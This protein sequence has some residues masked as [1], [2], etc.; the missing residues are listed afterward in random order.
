MSFIEPPDLYPSG[1]GRPAFTLLDVRAPVEVAAGGL[2]FAVTQPI[3]T[4]DERRRVGIRYR[5]AGQA[6]AV[7]LG[8][9]LTETTMPERVAAWREVVAAGPTAV[10]CWRGGLRSQLAGEFIGDDRVVRVDGGYK[11]VRNYLLG[12]LEPT[13]ARY[14]TFVIG[15]LTGSGKTALLERLKT[16]TQ[17]LRVLD[18]EGEA[19]HRGSAFGRLAE[20]QPA[21]ATF[22]NSVA[23]QLLLGS[24]KT[25]LVEDES[26]AIGRIDLPGALFR[27][28]QENP[29]VLVETPLSERVRRIHR[30]YVLSLSA[31]LGVAETRVYLSASLVRLRKRLSGSVTDAAL[32][33]LEG[34]EASGWHD[35]GAHEGWIRPLLER[36][37]DPLYRKGLGKIGSTRRLSRRPGGMLHMADTTQIRLTQTVKKGGCAAKIAAGTLSDLLKT[38]P[39]QQHPDLLVGTDFLDDAAVWRVSDTQLM[40]QTLDFF[41]PILDD[42]YDFGAVAAANALS[43]VFAMGATPT[44]A[45][46]ILAYPLDSLPLEVLRELM[47]GA[48]AKIDEAGALLVGGHSIDDDTLKLGFSVTG[49]THPDKLWSNRGA[50]VG[51]ALVLTKAV[52][53]GTLTGALKNGELDYGDL[54]EAITSMKTLNRLDLPDDL[55]HAVH[56]ATDVT[57]FGVLG[58]ALHLA[59]GSSVTLKLDAALPLLEHAAQTLDKNILTKAHRSNTDYVQAHVSGREGVSETQWWALTD[60]QTSGGLLLC[61]APEHVNTL[62][63]HL[64]PGFARATVIGSVEERAE[65]ALVL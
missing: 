19:R 48:V 28:V 55:H 62:L 15:G 32:R 57:G 21:Q 10:M 22:E 27:A 61:V 60:P 47:A 30:D 43:D 49:L 24:E 50:R 42:P 18:L 29:L 20:P 37:Y 33:V 17:D 4:D 9:A 5:E 65:K 6:E 23:A 54:A 14:D 13:L 59:E 16:E 41:T 46:T 53:T 7:E 36:Y 31:S 58:H 35:P 1:A 52:G 63:E 44:T 2:P 40:V 11:A 56:A 12:Q 25:L 38:L 34:A 39:R 3:L 8:Y 64:G 45:L 26:R 51:D